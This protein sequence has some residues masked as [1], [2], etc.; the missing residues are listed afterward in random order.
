VPDD[1]NVVDQRR[2]AELGSEIPAAL[3]ARLLAEHPGG[4]WNCAA[5]SEGQTC[6]LDVLLGIDGTR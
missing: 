4:A 3:R 1:E 6:C 5:H 2:L